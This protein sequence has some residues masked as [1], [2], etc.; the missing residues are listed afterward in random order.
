MC[1]LTTLFESKVSC[2]L[3]DRF[4]SLFNGQ[5]TPRYDYVTVFATFPTNDK[6]LFDSVCLALLSPGD[7]SKQDTHEHVQLLLILLE[8]LGNFIHNVIAFVGENCSVNRAIT[9]HIGIT[10]IVCA[11]HCFWLAAKGILYECEG[12]LVRPGLSFSAQEC[13]DPRFASTNCSTKTK[14]I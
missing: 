13:V 12:L 11:T 10:L 8:M 14:D 9:T 4:T 3:P 1:K 5:T 6:K 7:K 2:V